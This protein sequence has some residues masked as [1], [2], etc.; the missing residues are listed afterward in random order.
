MMLWLLGFPGE[1]LMLVAFAFAWGAVLG[2][3]ANVVLH[4]VP[5]GE[6]VVTAGSHCP[7]C[8][9]AIR[10]RDNIPV[11]GWLML[12]GRCRD[13]GSAISARYPRVE[14]ACG[15]LAALMAWSD[16]IAG[17]GLTT[18]DGSRTGLDRLL[19]FGDAQPLVAWGLHSVVLIAIVT[20]TILEWDAAA[21]S[22][23]SRETSSSGLCPGAAGLAAAVLAVA[24]CFPAIAPPH[25]GFTII[26]APWH[27]HAAAFAAATAGLLAGRL[28]GGWL[29]S[30][31]DRCIAALL[32]AA[33]GW[34]SVA[35]MAVVTLAVPR[36]NLGM[37]LGI[38]VAAAAGIL[39]FWQPLH[40]AFVAIRALAN[41]G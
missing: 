16:L 21:A 11:F 2:S 1:S 39:A 37:A 13:C 33:A 35:V 19:S 15:C 8:G 14:F 28:L 10:P 22:G 27:R 17:T 25:L 4:R 24:T 3:F 6:S 30:P 41:G 38:K 26:E 32:G 23:S 36:R 7:A 40:H 9:A 12:R 18:A 5:R 34:P 31:A 20:W 29:G